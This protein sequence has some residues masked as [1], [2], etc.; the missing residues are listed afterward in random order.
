MDRVSPKLGAIWT[1][2]PATTFRAAYTRSLGGVSFDQS[3]QLEPSQIAGF[4][5]TFRSLIPESVSGAL[6]AQRFE[7]FGVALDQRFPTRTYLGI[8]AEML[9]SDSTQ[10]LGTYDF[11][12]PNPAVSAATS[13][14]YMRTSH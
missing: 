12:F 8:S 14:P 2:R 5:Q 4:S 10:T 3:F 9:R 7:T 1:P 6:S 13:E 11:V